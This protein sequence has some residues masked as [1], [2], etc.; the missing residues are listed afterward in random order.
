MGSKKKEKKK[1]AA[2][3]VAS[4][5]ERHKKGIKRTTGHD[6]K[7]PIPPGLVAKPDRPRVMSK[8]KSWF[9]FIENKDKKKKLEIQVT[10]RKTTFRWRLEPFVETREPPPGYEFVPMGNPALTSACKE[11]SR[12]RG[13]MVF[14]VTS[15]Q[16]VFSKRLSL[17][18]NR[19][20]HH[21]REAIVEEAR[22]SLGDNNLIGDATLLGLPE[23]IPERQE[24]INAQADAALRDLFPR[25]PHTDRQMIIAH[26]FNKANIT[27]PDSPPVG[28]CANVTLSR[29][30]QLAVLAHIRHTH[31]RYDQLLRE[32]SYVN[33]RKAVESLCFDFLV[34]W[35]GDEETGRDQLDE[36]LCEV[37]VISDSESSDSESDDDDEDSD[38]DS[39]DDTDDDEKSSGVSPAESPRGEMARVNIPT[40]PLL[41]DSTRINEDLRG[42][43]GRPGAPEG[44]LLP[45]SPRGNENIRFGVPGRTSALNRPLPPPA[46]QSSY[47]LDARHHHHRDESPRVVQN[48]IRKHSRRDQE[49]KE[50][51]WAKRGFGRYQAV[52]EAWNQAVERQRL[53][54]NGSAG[55][56]APALM[57]LSRS[58]SQPWPPN[59]FQH[60]ELGM[61]MP[62]S[63]REPPDHARHQS[64]G[65]PFH[66]VINHAE[67]RNHAAFGDNQRLQSPYNAPGG[68]H[69]NG[70]GPIV[71]S[72]SQATG[73]YAQRFEDQ[74][75]QSIEPASPS[76]HSGWRH[77]P[78]TNV[79]SVS[80]P[81]RVAYRA[82]IPVDRPREVRENNTY[83][84]DEGFIHLSPRPDRLP[85][86]LDHMS[87][88]PNSPR[89]P[90][91]PTYDLPGYNTS[92]GCRDDTALPRM[93]SNPILINEDWRVL[94]SAARPI[95][96]PDSDL[97]HRQSLRQH[98]LPRGHFQEQV[99]L[100]I[101]MARQTS[102]IQPGQGA[103]DEA[104]YHDRRTNQP[105]MDRLPGDVQIL[106]VENKFPKQYGST[107][108][109]PDHRRTLA[110]ND[111]A[112]PLE[113]HPRRSEQVIARYDRPAIVSANGGTDRR[114][115]EDRR[116]QPQRH[117]RV[118]AY[119]FVHH[120]R[121]GHETVS[122]TDQHGRILRTERYPSERPSVPSGA[123]PRYENQT[124][125]FRRVDSRG[126]EIILLDE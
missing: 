53:E 4:A 21:I 92:Q 97:I 71:G 27:N 120:D 18:L 48:R 30:V 61:R 12:E 26:A 66:R 122:Y 116:M 20:G 72:R 22:K 38:D 58:A 79:S 77:R 74:P 106:R 9:E 119:E 55:P 80:G 110:T 46:A 51:K 113:P 84:N 37:I 56:E 1:R 98:T 64:S 73:G 29:R 112:P 39:D 124:A 111:N 100:P 63:P 3:G 76:G 62:I 121:P 70:V 107:P 88:A 68:S 17:H 57:P 44:S 6:W 69:I 60:S 16:G 35:R 28:L 59:H 52:H 109:Q 50:A 82:V 114:E 67:A 15:S 86:R 81:V 13:A 33:A 85:R 24:D 40:T 7:A 103:I 34:K 5:K 75:L 90:Q 2:L 115:L 93:E 8:H 123:G 125:Y 11:I 101:R 10:E 96:V 25:I 95:Y 54:Q 32:T 42:G 108:M 65:T 41:P 14:I 104:G 94:R 31:T 45:G 89:V 105:V 23:P 126:R 102:Q 87:L 91:S 99:H 78:E 49:K 19:V 118:V 117:E 36:I 83:G 47:P 43:L